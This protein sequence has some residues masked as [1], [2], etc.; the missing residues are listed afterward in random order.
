MRFVG[1]YKNG[2]GRINLSDLIPAYSVGGFPEDGLFMANH[3]ELV[4]QFSDG[5][6]AVA[7]NTDIQKGIEEAAYRGFTRANAENTRQ[8]SLLEELIDAV[9]EG[10]EIVVDGRSLT[11]AVDRRRSRNGYAFT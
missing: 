10:K 1:K 11:D 5:R 9:R 7:N 4:G 3:N 2:I 8:I 6:T